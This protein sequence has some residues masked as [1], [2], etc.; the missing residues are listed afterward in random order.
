MEGAFVNGVA[1]SSFGLGG[2][3]GLHGRANWSQLSSNPIHHFRRRELT[4]NQE[5]LSVAVSRS[6]RRLSGADLFPLVATYWPIQP[7]CYKTAG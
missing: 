1:N 4:V 6:L 7:A 5:F 2:F 3:G